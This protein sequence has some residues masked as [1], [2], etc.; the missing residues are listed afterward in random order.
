MSQP[1]QPGRRP[2][3]PTFNLYA[4]GRMYLNKPALDLLGIEPRGYVHLIP[5]ED[6]HVDMVGVD[7]PDD[8]SLRLSKSNTL[9]ATGLLSFLKLV[10]PEDTVALPYEE[11]IN[12]TVR[13]D[14]SQL[15]GAA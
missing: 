1:Y 8:N 15:A 4:N 14:F 10:A 2:T 3:S 6:G 5:E 7:G 11:G 9:C 13:L 12:R